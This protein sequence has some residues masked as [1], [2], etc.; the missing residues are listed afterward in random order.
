[1]KCLR[2][3]VMW[4][5]APV[6]NIH[7]SVK[8]GHEPADRVNLPE[9]FGRVGVPDPEPVALDCWTACSSCLS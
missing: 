5:E 7:K 1:M 2:E 6:S 8:S 3:H 9:S 4:S